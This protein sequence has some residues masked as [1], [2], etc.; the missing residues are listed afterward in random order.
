V[1]RCELTTEARPQVCI[2]SEMS[3]GVSE[4]HIEL[5]CSVVFCSLYC[6]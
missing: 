3:G 4:V 6:R 1:L 2:G 5:G